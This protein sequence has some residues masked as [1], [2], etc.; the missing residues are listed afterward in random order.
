MAQ[1]P[2]FA[3]TERPAIG[4]LSAPKVPPISEQQLTGGVP[5]L[6]ARHSGVPLAELRVAFPLTEKELAHPASVTVL[7]G[8]LFAGTARRD[9][10]ALAEAL[11]ELGAHLD[12]AVHD[13]YLVLSGSVLASNLGP[14][15]SLVCEM[16]TAA[17]YPKAE[18][19]ADARRA[20]DEALLALAQPEVIA[21]QELRRRLFKGHP[22]ATPIA[23][24]A[25]LRR[26]NEDGL[27]ELHRAVL[28]A[29][30]PVVVLVGDLQPSRAKALLEEHLGPWLAT[31]KRPAAGL[32]PLPEYQHGPIEVVARPNAVQSNIRLGGSAPAFSAADWPATN[33]AE[34]I[35]GGMFTSRLVANL[36]ER[37][38]YTYTPYTATRH[39]RAGSYIAAA[40]DVATEVTAPAL[41]E[42][43]YE[44][45]RLAATGVTGE[46]LELARHHAL[47]R[48]SFQVAT[49]SGLASSVVALAARGSG[50]SYLKSYPQAL[51]A[52]TKDEVDEAA[53]R[54]LAPGRLVT[55]VVG[56]P[57]VI[58]PQLSLLGDVV[59]RKT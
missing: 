21:R 15:L 41:V 3:K 38:G 45:G 22:Y 33:L 48:F 42:T 57:A 7:C 35:A 18:V 44:L 23:S 47:G 8:A 27:K 26:V 4:R 53:R 43:L 52:A 13:D 55:V 16:L 39:G 51:L 58:V 24:P 14:F 32:A 50:T 25:A 30:V 1:A 28:R 6:I 40:A 9:R 37:N 54:Y 12:A 10:T 2:T 19:R 34:S 56:D 36:R 59:V 31:R 11:E 49:Q 17:A 20:A 29:S 46:E 5:A